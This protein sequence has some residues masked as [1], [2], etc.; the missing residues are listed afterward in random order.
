MFDLLDQRHSLLERYELLAEN[1]GDIMLFIDG[2]NRIVEANAAARRAYG[3]SREEI[4]TRT[5]AE[6]H[7]PSALANMPTMLAR[8]RAHEAT[9]FSTA[10]QRRNGATFEAEVALAAATADGLVVGILRDT[11]ARRLAD[12]AIAA[13]FQ[14]AIE[15]SRL[16]SE[17]VATMSH[18]LR[19][20][21]N[22]IIGMNEL[23][24]ETEL[25]A[26]QLD[27]AETVRESSRLLLEIIDDVL[28][29]SKIEAGR[30]EL[31]LVDLDVAATV[32]SAAVLLASKAAQKGLSLT[33]FIDPQI[34]R[35]VRADPV[36]LRQILVNLIGNAV[37]FTT[38]GG[39]GIDVALVASDENASTL[40]FSVKDSGIGVDPA[41]A[42]RLF[43]PFLQIDASTTRQYGGTGLGLSISRRLAQL[44]GGD[45]AVESTPSEGSTFTFEAT[46]PH[47]SAHAGIDS[48]PSGVHS[49]LIVDDDTASRDVVKRYLS[50]WGVTVTAVPFA[51]DARALLR[52]RYTEGGTFD[53]AI[54][55]AMR[56]D[57]MLEL[58]ERIKSDPVTCGLKLVLASADGSRKAREAA[59]SV[60]FSYHLTKP[61]QQSQ[62]SLSV[63]QA[64]GPLETRKLAFES[65]RASVKPVP[66]RHRH[67]LVVEDNPVNQRLA[68][69]QLK[70]LGYLVTAA[71]NGRVALDC[72]SRDSY[73]PRINGLSDADYGRTDGHAG[74]SKERRRGYARTDRRDDRERADHRSARLP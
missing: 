10:Q 23:L 22:A 7:A 66:A 63:S 58:G 15:A 72:L 28:D 5:F 38:T 40:R 21:M 51:E 2:D 25:D 13:S 24:F 60:G 26:E 37:K 36:R 12:E 42:G 64:S 49:A 65:V 18:E 56:I 73:G 68:T 57:D 35:P 3:Y 1:A 30:M 48:A 59:A 62:L 54:L 46:F 16:K 33:T 61:V 32:E 50:A 67:V 47:S 19:T 9:V 29:F 52:E 17:F 39:V 70:K 34:S 14:K 69:Q 71:E 6:L 43:E 74:N 11:T 8:A 53:V 20:P 4:V 41:T 31:A 27:Y 55:G 45:I 44:M